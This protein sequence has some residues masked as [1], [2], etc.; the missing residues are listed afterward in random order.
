MRT[1]VNTGG[2][3][4]AG[5]EGDGDA[6]NWATAAWWDGFLSGL[7]HGFNGSALVIMLAGEMFAQEDDDGCQ[8]DWDQEDT[9][10]ARTF[11]R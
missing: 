4:H 3:W 5:G 10:E 7:P 2:R 9:E 11:R 6:A 8:T 1:S